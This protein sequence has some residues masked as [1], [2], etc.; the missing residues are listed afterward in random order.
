MTQFAIL[1]SLAQQKSEGHSGIVAGDSNNCHFHNHGASES[2]LPCLWSAR[3]K[4]E[5]QTRSLPSLRLPGVL[6]RP[7]LNRQTMLP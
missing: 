2:A 6:T 3:E 4:E 5:Y 1:A 7:D